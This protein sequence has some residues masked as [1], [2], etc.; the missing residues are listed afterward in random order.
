VHKYA[1]E[2]WAGKLKHRPGFSLPEREILTPGNIA[3][4]V[5]EMLRDGVTSLPPKSKRFR[6]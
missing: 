5:V 2:A 3:A 4:D 1:W 6:V